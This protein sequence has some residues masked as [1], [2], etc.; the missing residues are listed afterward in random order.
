MSLEAVEHN[1]EI[2]SRLCDELSLRPA[3]AYL[4]C[5]PR[6][7]GKSRIA[8]A[9]ALT[10]LCERAQGLNFC[11]NLADCPLREKVAGEENVGAAMRQCSCCA[12]CVQAALGI[13][14]DY[15]LVE[16]EHGRTEVRIE[17]VRDL[18]SRLGIK[19]LRARR[20]LAI[21]DDAETLSHPAQHAL[22][23]TL[24]EPPGSA[25]IFVV[26]ANQRALLPTVRSRLRLV[27]LRPAQVAVPASNVSNSASSMKPEGDAE[28]EALFEALVEAQ[29]I[30]AVEA[31]S[32]AEKFFSGGREQATVYLEWLAQRLAEVMRVEVLG[33]EALSEVPPHYRARVLE[34][35]RVLN[36]AT[37]LKALELALD[38]LDAVNAMANPV[39]QAESW[40]ISLGELARD[41]RL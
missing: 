5:G 31:R 9:L 29:R 22:L 19:P 25:I 30:G 2:L 26:T 11:C 36:L 33:E 27:R 7:S 37:V 28:I 38:A 24:E 39:A 4:L 18:I 32:L 8:R 16:R 15:H 35:A 14:P 23:K 3:H 21:I 1:R 34:I 17:Q 10:F 20:R 12:G 41:E 13:H 6:G 40:W